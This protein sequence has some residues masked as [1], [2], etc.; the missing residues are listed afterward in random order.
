MQL[1]TEK[2]GERELAEKISAFRSVHPE[3]AVIAD[4]NECFGTGVLMLYR[5]GEKRRI[6]A[7]I[8]YDDRDGI[9]FYPER[10]CYKNISDM[11]G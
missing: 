1:L 4:W 5:R 3:Y 8:V 10:G 2:R 6:I 9:L 11:L 7:S